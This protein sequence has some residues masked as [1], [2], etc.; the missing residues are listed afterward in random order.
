[1][2]MLQESVPNIYYKHSAILI[3]AVQSWP[4]KIAEITGYAVFEVFV[5]S[6]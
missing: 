2:F 4:Q 3:S 1:M 6:Q 5:T